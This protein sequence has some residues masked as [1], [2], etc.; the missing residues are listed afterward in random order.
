MRV[1]VSL[2]VSA[3]SRPDPSL[4]VESRAAGAL[5]RVRSSGVPAMAGALLSGVFAGAGAAQ[6]DGRIAADPAQPDRARG[7]D[8]GSQC[9]GAVAAHRLDQAVSLRGDACQC[10]PRPRTRQT[11]WRRGRDSRREGDFGARAQSDRRLRRRDL[12][13]DTRLRSRSRR[14]GQSLCGAVRPQGRPV[15]GR[16]RTNARTVRRTVAGGDAGGHVDRAR[17]RGRDGAVVGSDIRS[18]RLFDPAQAS[19]AAIICICSRA[20]MPCSIIPFWIP[21]SAICW[22]R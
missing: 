19:S 16:R 18:A 22:R 5:Q 3:R 6:R 11:I 9:A 12:F 14:P 20:A 8:R 2:H 21:I 17:G 7:A 13:S 15:S 10:Q 1:G 4:R